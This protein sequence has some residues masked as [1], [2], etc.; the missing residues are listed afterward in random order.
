M[1]LDT[2]TGARYSAVQPSE[3]TSRLGSRYQQ[4]LDAARLSLEAI[5]NPTEQEYVWN[6]HGYD[7]VLEHARAMVDAA[8]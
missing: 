2:P 5:T 4:T 6:T 3:L 8:Q 7:V 1:R